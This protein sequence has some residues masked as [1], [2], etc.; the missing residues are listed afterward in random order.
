MSDV[1][2]KSL[3]EID[4]KVL[5]L[6]SENANMTA[7]DIAARIG[8]SIPAANK[9]ISKLTVSGIISQ[10][11]IIVDAEKIG[12]PLLAFILV[13]LERLT[14]FDKLMECVQR[15]QDVLECFAT[16]GEFD[17]IVKVRAKNMSDLEKKIIA[18]KEVKGIVKTNT[19]ISLDSHKYLPSVLP[20][21]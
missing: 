13:V 4:L 15:D 1:I 11:T 20:D 2:K 18:I 5:K 21:M 19:M 16:T 8:L 17:Y 6:L 3:D 12:K 10:Y 14:Y 9:R 7:T